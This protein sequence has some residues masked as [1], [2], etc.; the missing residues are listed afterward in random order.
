MKI[1]KKSKRSIAKCVSI[2]KTF[3]LDLRNFDLKF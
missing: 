3:L 2:S 1:I